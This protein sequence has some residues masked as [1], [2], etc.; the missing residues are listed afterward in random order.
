MTDIK[1]TI[2]KDILERMEKYPE[3]NWEKIAQGAVEKYLEKLEVADK[4]TSNSSFT[5]EDA[6]KLGDEIKQKM[7]ERHKYYM[8]TLKK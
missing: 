7:W 2:S 4:L 1:F 5:L 3:I 6:D 8:E